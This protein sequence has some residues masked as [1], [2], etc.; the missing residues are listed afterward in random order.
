MHPLFPLFDR[1]FKIITVYS[2]NSRLHPL[3]INSERSHIPIIVILFIG[4]GLQLK[5]KKVGTIVLKLCS[6]ITLLSDY[7]QSGHHLRRLFVR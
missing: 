4:R 3:L 2:T 6:M 5:N 1:Y 7:E